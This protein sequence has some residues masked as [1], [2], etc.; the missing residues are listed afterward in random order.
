MNEAYKIICGDSGEIHSGEPVQ[1]IVTSPP[2]F[3]LRE[4]KTGGELGREF[5]P[6]IYILRVALILNRIG[7]LLKP[8]G[9][10]FVNIGDSYMEGSLLGI[11]WRIAEKM[12]K[13]GWCLRSEIIWCLSQNTKVYAQMPDREGP[14]QLHDLVRMNPAN[15]KLWT[16][17][18]WSQVL[19]WSESSCE[20]P[21]RFILRSGEEISSTPNHRWPLLDGTVVDAKDIKVGDTLSS[22]TLPEPHAASG[23]YD[24]DMA[25]LCGLYL[26]EGSMSGETIQLAGGTH[27]PKRHSKV[28][29]IAK[30]YGGTAN[31]Y[32]LKGHSVTVNVRSKILLGAISHFIS[33]NGAKH[34]RLEK[35][36]FNCSNEILMS[37][38]TGYLD[39]DGHFEIKNNRWRIGFTRNYG[40]A[41]DLRTL[42]A[43]LGAAITLKPTYSRIGKSKI[44][45]AFRGEIRFMRSGHR[46]EKSKNEIIAI[47]NGWPGKYYDIGIADSPHLFALASGVLTHN[48]KPNAMP[49]SVDNRPVKSHEHL[50]MFTHS[51]DGYYYDADAIKE[52]YEEI[53]EASLR[54]AITEKY[55]AVRGSA[56][57]RLGR[58]RLNRPDPNGRNRRSVWNIPTE[59][60][61]GNDHPAPFPEKLVLLCILAGTKPGD[62]VMDPFAG[63]FTTGIV[64]LAAGRKFIGVEISEAYCKAGE[65]R[66]QNEVGLLPLMAASKEN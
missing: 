41:D 51:S 56:G 62:I 6:E 4:Y 14:I 52:P 34:K 39:G 13:Y 2:Y 46:N 31:I 24:T 65:A 63:S 7:N 9:T 33:G 21:I 48:S 53:S 64:A 43:R 36:V 47:K 57:E 29:R 27:E 60:S 44:F 58:P 35:R 37:V 1:C 3:G 50:F 23:P 5:D 15:V 28:V 22:T 49:E 8:D 19:G 55:K 32:N 54:P 12:K 16:G 45:E 20:N 10:Y 38:L 30:K 25:W 59:P 40:L 26:A 17:E 11:P 18:K 61:V 66:I 42:C